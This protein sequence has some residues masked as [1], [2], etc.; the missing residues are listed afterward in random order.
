MWVFCRFRGCPDQRKRRAS[1]RRFGDSPLRSTARRVVKGRRGRGRTRVAGRPLTSPV[2]DRTPAM[3]VLVSHPVAGLPAASGLS[4]EPGEGRPE[5]PTETAGMPM[6]R[7]AFSGGPA[8]RIPERFLCTAPEMNRAGSKPD[9]SSAESYEGWSSAGSGLSSPVRTQV[10]PT[11][12]RKKR[13]AGRRRGL[14]T[15]TGSFEP[16]RTSLMSSTSG[17]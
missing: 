11:S 1:R 15:S 9:R 2:A 3:I 14:V 8:A 5:G 13:W 12:A 7:S 17:D 6:C 16:V 10:G 4:R